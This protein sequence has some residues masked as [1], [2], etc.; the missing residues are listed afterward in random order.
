MGTVPAREALTL[1]QVVCPN[2]GH[3]FHRWGHQASFDVSTMRTLLE[4]K[5]ILDAVEERFFIE[6][7]GVGWPRRLAGLLKK[8]L[9]WRGIGTYG[10]ARNVF[11][12]ARKP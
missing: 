3:Q 9:S 5:F 2:C 10:A 4:R 8:F 7:D 11:F 12:V 6:W 1:S